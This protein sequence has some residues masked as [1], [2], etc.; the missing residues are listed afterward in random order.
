MA[1]SIFE[2]F[3]GTYERHGDY[4]FPC[5]ISPAEKELPIGIY[6]QRHLRYMKEHRDRNHLRIIIMRQ[7]LILCRFFL[8]PIQNKPPAMQVRPAIALASS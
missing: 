5:L 1:K 7:R 3:G 4:F 8:Y 2:Q 6:G